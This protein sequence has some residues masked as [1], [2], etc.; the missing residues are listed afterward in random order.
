MTIDFGPAGK[1]GC[2]KVVTVPEKSTVLEALSTSVP[3]VT[4]P[5]YGMEHFVEAIN[6]IA[7]DL[8]GDRGWRFEVNGR[9][10]NVPAER[11]LLKDGDWIKWRYFSGAC[12]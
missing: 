6:G 4:S 5:R 2:E 9:G 12:S 1:P 10:S 11:Y 3:V 7:N 8:A